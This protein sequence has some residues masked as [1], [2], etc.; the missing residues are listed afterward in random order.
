MIIIGQSGT[1]LRA[2]EKQNL[3]KYFGEVIIVDCSQV[4]Q[5]YNQNPKAQYVYWRPDTERTNKNQFQQYC[6]QEC[7]LASRGVK[8]IN[9]MFG[10]PKTQSK[11]RAFIEWEKNGIPHPKWF[12][13]ENQEIFF[14]KLYSKENENIFYETSLDRTKIAHFPFLLRLNN[15]VTGYE[16]VLVEPVQSRITKVMELILTSATTKEDMRKYLDK[17][18]KAHKNPK[19][20]GG[21]DC[22][23][24]AV[25]F[26][27]TRNK[28]GYRYS[29]RIIVAADK[30]VAGYARMTKG[31]DWC[32]ITKKW[33]LDMAEDWIQANK[34]C[35]EFCTV[36]YED[37]IN[38]VKCLGSNFLGVDV[39]IRQD[40]KHYFLEVQSGFSVGYLNHP[41]WSPPFYNPCQP[42]ELVDYLI[43]NMDMLKKRI[44][45][46]CMWLNKDRVFDTAFKAIKESFD[47]QDK[48]LNQ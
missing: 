16:T 34:Q 37:I 20:G 38:A 7:A 41:D 18:E 3:E 43:E 48:R 44:P 9:S 28:S 35:Q 27:E 39:I 12:E 42:K 17:I 4:L 36:H 24:L 32:A 2:F 22:K 11:E 15:S 19:Y 21:I 6:L 40:G 13:W 8:F 14:K 25:S 46:Y 45:F 5:T 30:I 26:I 31:N 23:K 33:T 1:R 29:F 47:K 10:F